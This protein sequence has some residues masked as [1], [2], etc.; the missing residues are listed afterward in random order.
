M[1]F[2]SLS[3]SQARPC[4]LNCVPGGC[5][6]DIAFASSGRSCSL[7]A[8]VRA[9]AGCAPTF[10]GRQQCAFD[11]DLSRTTDS[12]ALF[13]VALLTASPLPCRVFARLRRANDLWEMW[14]GLYMLD[15]WE[16][17]IF[18]ALIAAVGGSAAAYVRWTSGATFAAEPY[19]FLLCLIPCRL[20]RC[21]C[22]CVELH[23]FVTGRGHADEPPIDRKMSFGADC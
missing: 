2:H 23:L 15:W 12:R 7:D 5:R 17:M 18:S 11:L 20:A 1:F 21:C 13:F 8:R 6:I 22:V 10:C 19:R 14:T 4:D 16:K 9:R 3:H